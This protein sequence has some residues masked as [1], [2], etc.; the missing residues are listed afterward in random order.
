MRLSANP[1]NTQGVQSKVSKFDFHLLRQT[2]L[3]A[4]YVPSNLQQTSRAMFAQRGCSEL[5]VLCHVVGLR[6]LA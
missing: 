5:D 6:V 1:L 4:P 2:F 3:S